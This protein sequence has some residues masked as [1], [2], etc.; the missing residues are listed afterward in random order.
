M[1][2]KNTLLGVVSLG[3]LLATALSFPSKRT[4]TAPT[5][6]RTTTTRSSRLGSTGCHSPV[7]AWTSAPASVGCG[8]QPLRLRAKVFGDPKRAPFFG[9]HPRREV[10][11][12]SGGA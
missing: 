6:D 8:C 11:R 1:R 12:G 4:P 9:G 7:H 2:H 5:Q 10:G 3:V